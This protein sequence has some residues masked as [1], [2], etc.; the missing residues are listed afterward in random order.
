M[1]YDFLFVY[2]YRC[3]QVICKRVDVWN[4]FDI[5]YMIFLVHVVAIVCVYI[6][7]KYTISSLL[8]IKQIPC[9]KLCSDKQHLC[10][11]GGT[12]IPGALHTSHV[13]PPCQRK[14]KH[15]MLA[16]TWGIVSSIWSAH[17]RSCKSSSS[18]SSGTRFLPPFHIPREVSITARSR[19]KSNTMEADFHRPWESGL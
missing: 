5:L 15:K 4:E 10:P 12:P 17:L 11:F 14:T 3:L 1:S 2:T 8:D 16:L 6:Y 9:S 18:W 13:P 7:H 19:G